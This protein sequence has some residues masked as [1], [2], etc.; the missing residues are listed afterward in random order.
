MYVHTYTSIYIQGMDAWMA[1]N[2]PEKVL[3]RSNTR[4]KPDSSDAGK[5]KRK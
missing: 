4:D 3:E 5:Y 1:A 2:M